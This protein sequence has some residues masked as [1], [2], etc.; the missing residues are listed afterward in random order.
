MERS[1]RKER[2]KA[3]ETMRALSSGETYASACSF[4]S[5]LKSRGV[6]LGLDRMSRLMAALNHPELG[7]PC[8][9]VA[10]T[11]GKGSVAAMLESIFRIAGWRTGLYTSPHLVRL[12]ERIQVDRQQLS[13]QGIIDY[14][15]GLRSIVSVMEATHGG[16]PSYFELM[17][18]MAFL[19][20]A[21]KKCD[22]AIVE[23][24][25]G[26]RMDATNVVVPEVS[27]ITSIGLDHTEMLGNTL[28]A[29]ATEKAGIIKPGR[30][31]V[32]GHVPAEAENVLRRVAQ[33]RDARLV[34]VADEFGGDLS[35]YPSTNLEAVYQRTNAGTATLVARMMPPRW[36]ISDR[37]ISAGLSSVE[38]S[39]RWQRF[40]VGGR[41]VILDASHNA[42][43]AQSLDVSLATLVREF[44]RAPIVVIGVLG[45]ERARP[46][47]NVVCRHSREVQLVRPGQSRASTYEELEA[48]VPVG[49][50]GQITRNSIENIFPNQSTCALGVPGDVVVVTGSIYVAGEVLAR[51]EPARG[52]YEGHLQDF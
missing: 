16:A 17:T 38:W 51:L 43:G 45:A 4:L 39:G 47:L 13:E 27:V 40:L 8:I 26:G 22:V 5:E 23:V 24:G 25:L 35:G 37:V 30:P 42:E 19:H 15:H 28:A 32:I 33:E 1:A 3:D 9:H 49:Y 12:G 29:I 6:S 18:A 20:F 44:D 46:L 50:D 36:G 7:V 11:N 41:T 2:T 34:S 14:V 10:G 21:R 48:F 31:V 52:P